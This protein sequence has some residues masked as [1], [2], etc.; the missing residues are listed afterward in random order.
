VPAIPKTSDEKI[1]RAARRLIEQRGKDRFSL[2]DVAKAVGIRAPSIYNRFADRAELVA[3]V[4]LELWRDLAA[5]LAGATP[6]ADPVDAL[7]SQARAYR[8]FAKANPRGYPLMYESG[9]GDSPSGTAARSA[10]LA[11]TWAH[12]VALVGE[13][14]ALAAARVLTPFLH[15]F[16]SM[17]LASAFRL[18]GG[19]DDAFERGVATI[20]AGLQV[21]AGRDERPTESR[22]Q[23][24]AARRAH[25]RRSSKRRS[26]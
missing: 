18:G 7:K 2:N 15:G 23:K 8:Q 3:A 22:H 14:D 16:V 20:L 10:G 19:I 12:F 6:A 5:A 1:I 26:R 17:E 21:L 13:Q 11:P 24:A 25:R 4:E 9:A